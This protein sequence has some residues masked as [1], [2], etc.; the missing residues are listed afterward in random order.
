[1]DGGEQVGAVDVRA[2]LVEGRVHPVFQPVVRLADGAVVGYEALSRMVGAAPDRWL[3]L[4]SEVGLRAD[5]ELACV[6]AIAAAGPPPEGCILFVNTSPAALVDRRLEAL[7]PALGE[8]LVLELTEQDAVSDYEGLRERLRWWREAGVRLAIDDTGAGYSSLTHVLQL[9][10]EFVKLD[11]GLISGLDGDKNGR[12]LVRSLVI[13]AE[14]VGSTIVAEGVERPEELE[15]LREVGVGLG[16]GFLLGRP[17]E[18]WA[19]SAWAPASPSLADRLARARDRRDACDIAVGHLWETWDGCLPSAYLE[20]N[21]LMRCQAHRGYWQVLDGVPVGMG[22]MGRTFETGCRQAVA[23]AAAAPDF[24]GAFPGLQSE[25]CVPLRDGDKVVGVL[26]VEWLTSRP[27]VAD[28]DIDRVAELLD[29]RLS[30]FPPERESPLA[31]LA[32]TSQSLAGLSDAGD[33]EAAIV[34]VATE[35]SGMSS[36]MLALPGDDGQLGV[37]QVIG[38]LSSVLRSLGPDDVGRLATLVE[39]VTTCWSDG[40]AEGQTFNGLELLRS[41]GAATVAVLPVST[42]DRRSGVLVVASHLPCPLTTEETEPL[43]LLAAEAGRC[44]DLAGM[45]AELRYRATRDPLTGLENHSAFHEALRGADPLPAVV[46]ADIDRFKQ[47]NDTRGHLAGD[48]LL[49]ELAARL[50][51]EVWG[52]GR[53]YRVGGDELAGLFEGLGGEGALEVAARLCAAAGEVLQPYGAS[54]SAGVVVPFPGEQPTSFL[55]R[56]DA[57]LYDAKRGGR[58]TVQLARL[59]DAPPIRSPVAG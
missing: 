17:A 23:D 38:P 20:R 30:S 24:L 8:S 56:A 36:A 14:E 34:R 39:R 40:S 44:L 41:R 37:R 27:T 48:R 35:V 10:P 59:V 54:L 55:A 3:S 6:R 47:V 5:L 15:V 33:V 11:R 19:P 18:P 22:V 29:E 53:L 32:R 58:G 9:A 21:G 52:R 16:Q 1:M 26:N 13:F 51:A 46:L 2:L 31:R 57:A 43:E 7:R 12:A 25:V 42:L 28:R 4:A 49:R 50:S 45:V